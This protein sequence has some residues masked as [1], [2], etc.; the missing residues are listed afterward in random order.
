MYFI[1]GSNLGNITV[2]IEAPFICPSSI[3]TFS[4]SL[5]QTLHFISGHLMAF[6]RLVTSMM[7]EYLF[8]SNHPP[9]I[10]FYHFLALNANHRHLISVI[11]NLINYI[12]S[13][14]NATLKDTWEQDFGVIIT[15]DL[16]HNILNQVR[17]SSICARNG[18]M[19]CK[20]YF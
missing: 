10:F 6:S 5:V 18:L 14:T 15:E 1:F 8:L 13:D 17:T 7:R 11:Y 12:N 4:P 16:W 9:E 19:Q 3:T 2:Y 20:Y